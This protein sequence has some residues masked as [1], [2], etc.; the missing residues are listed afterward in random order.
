VTEY[1]NGTERQWDRYA[2]RLE[3]LLWPEGGST[4]EVRVRESQW[5]EPG[6]WR[7]GLEANYLV[8]VVRPVSAGDAVAK[9]LQ[10]LGFP[11]PFDEDEDEDRQGRYW[12]IYVEPCTTAEW[13]RRRLKRAERMRSKR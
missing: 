4:V 7:D 1:A 11:E 8:V 9:R 10:D 13:M 3:A 12:I 6:N 5:G 2:A